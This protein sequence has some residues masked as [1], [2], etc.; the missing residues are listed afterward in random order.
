MVGYRLSAGRPRRGHGVSALDEALGEELR[1]DVIEGSEM[2]L[3]ALQGAISF[4]EAVERDELDLRAAGATGAGTGR[5][6]LPGSSRGRRCAVR[7]APDRGIVRGPRHAPA[8]D[9]HDEPG[10]A[11]EAARAAREPRS[12]C[13]P[14][15]GLGERA[16]QWP[17]RSDGDAAV[18]SEPLRRSTGRAILAQGRGRRRALRLG[19]RPEQPLHHRL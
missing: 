4:A 18:V 5:Y 12:W 6:P 17:E 7:P 2:R 14:G 13:C 1:E 10:R 11:S 15:R 3:E 8:Q 16:R 19:A 9:R